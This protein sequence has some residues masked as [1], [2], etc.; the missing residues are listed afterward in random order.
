MVGAGIIESENDTFATLVFSSGFLNLLNPIDLLSS[1]S[2]MSWTKVIN[3]CS[4]YF[5]VWYVNPSLTD[6]GL[7]YNLD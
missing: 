2:S 1:P 7:T 4:Y 6:I 5:I 3:M